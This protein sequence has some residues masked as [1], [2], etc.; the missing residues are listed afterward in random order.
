MV[1]MKL[2]NFTNSTLIVTWGKKVFKIGMM[3]ATAN[4]LKTVVEEYGINRHKMLKFKKNDKNKFR[5]ICNDGKC[6]WTLYVCD[7]RPNDT[8]Q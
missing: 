7:I 6:P 2:I 3:F 4:I 1:K 5:V 8:T